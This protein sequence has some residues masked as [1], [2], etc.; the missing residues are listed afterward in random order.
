MSNPTQAQYVR[1]IYGR[2][3]DRKPIFAPDTIV[4]DDNPFSDSAHVEPSE[5]HKLFNSLLNSKDQV[6]RDSFDA[7]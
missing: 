3:M 6:D 1:S 5:E 7:S 2:V 4:A